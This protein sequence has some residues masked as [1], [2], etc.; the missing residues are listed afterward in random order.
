MRWKINLNGDAQETLERELMAIY[1]AADDLRDK[2][3]D[4]TINGRN[5]PGDPDGLRADQ[6]ERL[7]MARK[8]EEVRRWAMNAMLELQIK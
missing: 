1:G 2:V 6:G 7:A 8:V 3:G 5:Y 4:L